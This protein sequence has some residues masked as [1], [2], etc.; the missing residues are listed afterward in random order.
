MC[1]RVISLF[2][3]LGSRGRL[4]LT[5]NSTHTL[6]VRLILCC[7][8]GPVNIGLALK[9]AHEFGWLEFRILGASQQM[10]SI[11]NPIISLHCCLQFC[12]S[13]Y[14]SVTFIWHIKTVQHMKI[15]LSFYDTVII[16]FFLWLKFVVMS[17][18]VGH[19]LQHQNGLSPIANLKFV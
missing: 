19:K 17:L 10:Q 13:V 14:L 5:V 3:A 12:P 11:S 6:Q 8:L 4:L 15:R 2:V 18:W 16:P 9:V 7:A 1:C